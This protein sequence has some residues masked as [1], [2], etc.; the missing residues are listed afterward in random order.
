MTSRQIECFLTVVKNMSFSKAADELFISQPS[1]SR[2]IRELEEELGVRLFIRG[3]KF[4][5]LSEEGR[6]WHDYF[7]LMVEEFIKARNLTVKVHGV[8]T[9]KVAFAISSLWGY[10]RSFKSFVRYFEKKYP[11]ILVERLA[12]APVHGIIESYGDNPPTVFFHIEKILWDL[13][14]KYNSSKIGDVPL[15]FFFS[16]S[17]PFASNP[18]IT[19]ADFS[20]QLFLIVGDSNDDGPITKPDIIDKISEIFVGLNVAPPQY[21]FVAENE[22][23]VS[24]LEDGDGVLMADVWAR[25]A[26]N[27]FLSCH[28]TN[29][30]ENVGVAWDNSEENSIAALF[31]KE[32]IEFFKAH[33]LSH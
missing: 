24:M 32:S 33:P 10:N 15:A 17:H 19:T 28:V 27:S 18:N 8:Q 23:S 14:E 7:T 22:I 3:N 20:N 12:P 30:S 9:G 16:K 25:Y 1:V 21:R 4:I 5:A 26:H 2:Y 31:A 11:H 13:P 29:Y 6:V